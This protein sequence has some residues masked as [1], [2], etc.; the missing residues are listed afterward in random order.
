MSNIIHE[1]P[2]II[3]KLNKEKNNNLD[4]SHQ[5]NEKESRFLLDV[6]ILSSLKSIP[7]KTISLNI[8]LHKNSKDENC[9]QNKIQLNNILEDK[10]NPI[11][12]KPISKSAFTA[13][14]DKNN[15]SNVIQNNITTNNFYFNGG[16]NN[17]NI[18]ITLN[19]IFNNNYNQTNNFCFFQDPYAQG[20][21]SQL[22]F[23]QSNHP[24]LLSYKS[25]K[26]FSK[27]FYNNNSNFMWT[28]NKISQDS[29]LYPN[30]LLN[31][32]N[33]N[34]GCFMRKMSNG[35]INVNNISQ[36]SYQLKFPQPQLVAAN[37]E[38]LNK[39]R[40][41]EIKQ[42]RCKVSDIKNL[43]SL[44]KKN[45]KQ[46]FFK[47]STDEGKENNT[48]GNDDNDYIYRRIN[49]DNKSGPG[50]KF[51]GTF[52][53]YRK[54]R[55]VNPI[56]AFHCSHPKCEFSYDTFKQLQNHHYKMIPECQ[57]DSIQIMKLIYDTKVILLNLLNKIPNN[58][59]KKNYF[60]ELYKNSLESI[61]LSCY[62]EV[63]TGVDLEDDRKLS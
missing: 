9:N 11:I 32:S 36:L 28:S 50:N 6:K 21:D 24:S 31:N 17:T 19:N 26:S 52:R 51:N 63:Y 5:K 12:N 8:D 18:N 43:E 59:E 56:K 4:K 60:S 7:G 22:Y 37:H 35:S 13:N 46:I 2:N 42:E 44:K 48:N 16:V 41:E 10:Q 27:M 20:H 55:K 14:A 15:K 40:S 39:K 47:T 25:K 58:D 23:S 1:Y 30:Y 45:K 54:R 61:S 33:N 53:K 29:F 57:N 3:E 62:T 34:N 49:D 38:F